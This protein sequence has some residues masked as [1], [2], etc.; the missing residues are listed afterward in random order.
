M[1]VISLQVV[2]AAHTAIQRAARR[3]IPASLEIQRHT[4]RVAQATGFDVDPEPFDGVPYFWPEQRLLRFLVQEVAVDAVGHIKA[5]EKDGGWRN[6]PVVGCTH[7]RGNAI[8]ER[9]FQPH[10]YPYFLLKAGH[11]LHHY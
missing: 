5:L 1:Q 9:C 3:G 4:W 11:E 6:H 2:G 7:V 8:Q 10:S